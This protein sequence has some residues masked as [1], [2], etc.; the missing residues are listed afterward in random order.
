MCNT[1]APY[2]AISAAL[3]QTPAGMLPQRRDA[4]ELAI[5]PG[6]A[7]LWG[8]TLGDA[9]ITIALLDGPCDLGHP[10]F[11]GAAIEQLPFAGT[12]APGGLAG[13]HGTHT[14]SVIFAQHTSPVRGVA[15]S[16]RGL[17]IPIFEN[18][19]RGGISACSQPELARAI[20]LAASHG[21]DVI[22]VS[23]GQFS[24]GGE[25][26]PELVAAVH[27]C[28]EEGRLIVAAAG[29]DGCPCL[30]VPGALPSVLAVGA[31][32]ERGEPVE[33]SNW[34]GAYQTNGV[35]APG[36]G[37]AGALPGGR[38]ARRSGTSFATPIVAGLAALLLSLQ[39]KRGRQP[40][41]R[42]VRAAILDSA[43][44]CEHQAVHE[45]QR[46]LAGR[47][48]VSGAVQQLFKGDEANM[49]N[50]AVLID[51]EGKTAAGAAESA[52]SSALAL[53][54]PSSLAE[55]PSA[56]R[57]PGS[58]ASLAS[59]SSAVL[60]SCAC[61]HAPQLVYAIG[62]LGI[63]FGTE[64]RMDSIQ[65]SADGYLEGGR[66]DMRS[67]PGLLRHLLGW[68]EFVT[69]ARPGEPPPSADPTVHA[70]HVYD[71]KSVI[72]V[73]RQDDSPVYAIRPR[74]PYAE[75]AYLE[76]LHFWM[77]Q[78]GYPDDVV[79][80]RDGARRYSYY[81]ALDTVDGTEPHR[82]RDREGDPLRIIERV[83]IPGT[84]DGTVRLY[85]GSVVPVIV[86]EMRGTRSWSM[87]R[88]IELHVSKD[89]T[90]EG[91]RRNLERLAQRFFEEARNPGRTP[92]QRALN[93]A[94]TQTFRSV[95]DLRRKFGE[96]V[97][98]ELDSITVKRSP[99][100]RVDSDCYDVETAF[101]DPANNLR[102]LVVLA[103]TYDTSDTVPVLLGSD[104]EYRKR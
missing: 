53:V 8:E 82:R 86:P 93:F 59:V 62:D 21:A 65:Q 37:I 33:F 34:G 101:F 57:E 97:E 55:D 17:V 11:A 38:L 61:Q 100:C 6:L 32:N 87:D 16:A 77:E 10:C 25:A 96:N 44:G 30:H 94:A 48:N 13:E 49:S 28:G 9:A 102:S 73:L 35:V 66:L 27:E 91:E 78:E 47:L 103:R 26:H 98:W 36:I 40:D 43:L 51:N 41:T 76:L 29:N 20:R 18:R 45:C 58:G 4:D 89:N 12:S 84:L 42:A 15:P 31:M 23:G 99:V 81:P 70:P 83:A 92:E 79:H 72:W 46:L 69:V 2:E 64:A 67:A 5:I 56:A 85:N 75:D 88:L 60:P 50:Q 39:K 74:G 68:R 24:Y 90:Y 19:E 80:A 14:A 1:Q 52:A 54:G 7:Q 3:A 63:D 104:R 22:N 71:A 95:Q